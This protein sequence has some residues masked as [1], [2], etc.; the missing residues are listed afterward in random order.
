MH[1]TTRSQVVGC[2]GG[3]TAKVGGSNRHVGG[4]AGLCARERGCNGST[5]NL[6]HEEARAAMCTTR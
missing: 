6:S 1:A 3:L 2:G 5:S 4:A